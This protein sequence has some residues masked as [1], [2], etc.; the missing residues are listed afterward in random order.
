[1]AWVTPSGDP[2]LKSEDYNSRTSVWQNSR[3]L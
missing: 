1:M 3:Y 2:L